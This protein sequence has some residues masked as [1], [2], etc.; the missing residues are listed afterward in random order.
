MKDVFF[1]TS[2][3]QKAGLVHQVFVRR[4]ECVFF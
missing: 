2:A 3:V 4:E 1:F